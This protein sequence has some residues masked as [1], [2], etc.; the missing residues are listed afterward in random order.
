MI[1]TEKTASKYDNFLVDQAANR[2]ENIE[3]ALI[4]DPSQLGHIYLHI[5]CVL[6]L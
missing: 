1:S 3:M 5:F 4:I 6:L 2:A